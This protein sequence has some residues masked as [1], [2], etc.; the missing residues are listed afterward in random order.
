[1]PFACSCYMSSYCSG[2]PPLANCRVSV[3]VGSETLCRCVGWVT[4][5]GFSCERESKRKDA[6]KAQQKYVHYGVTGQTYP[7]PVIVTCDL[8]QREHDMNRQLTSTVTS[9][10]PPNK[11]FEIITHAV[12]SSS[13][14]TLCTI[15]PL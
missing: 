13:S 12:F 9:V 8:L 14:D 2:D 15:A 11:V 3:Q 6:S 4:N 5:H 7:L 10:V 1:M